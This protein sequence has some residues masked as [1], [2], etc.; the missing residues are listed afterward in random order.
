MCVCCS[1]IRPKSR[2]A[3]P[4]T[5]ACCSLV[6]LVMSSASLHLGTAVVDSS[7]AVWRCRRD[8]TRQG[9]DACRRCSIECASFRNMRGLHAS[10]GCRPVLANIGPSPFEVPLT[11]AESGQMLL[12]MDIQWPDVSL[13][14]A[15]EVDQIWGLFSQLRVDF[16]HPL[17]DVGRPWL[18]TKLG[19]G[20]GEL[21][22]IQLAN[23]KV[24]CRG[25]I[26]TSGGPGTAP[27]PLCTTSP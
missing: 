19:R 15:D 14:G 3:R 21:K 2:S 10:S 13:I 24:C 1:T 7:Y 18:D 20:W 26:S 12:G 8:S 16:N 17:H 9:T 25:C 6:A 11:S 4:F 22:R 27:T 23:S 5:Q